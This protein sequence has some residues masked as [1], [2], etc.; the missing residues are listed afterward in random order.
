MAG[1]QNDGKKKE[2]SVW[3]P[4]FTVVL[5]AGAA[6]FI[7][8]SQLYKLMNRA[9]ARAA[10][11]TSGDGDGRV[12]VRRSM[13]PTQQQRMTKPGRVH[14]DERGEITKVEAP[15]PDTVLTTYCAAKEQGGSS[16]HPVAVVPSVPAR[17][18]VRLGVYRDLNDM[19][20]L[21]G[22][23]LQKDTRTGRWEVERTMHPLER[24][25]EVKSYRM[26]PGDPRLAHVDPTE[27]A[28]RDN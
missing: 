28:R 10:E 18:G 5:L 8:P 21:Y 25:R 14:T 26:L 22:I 19:Q 20:A 4:I 1:K 3:G 24:N 27:F 7:V 2:G 16:C 15:K 12:V 23:P 13:A 11:E 6:M 17:R 9:D